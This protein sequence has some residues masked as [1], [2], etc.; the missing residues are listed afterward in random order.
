[1][2]YQY[3][4]EIVE[5]EPL[6]WFGVP[7]SQTAAFCKKHGIEAD[8]VKSKFIFKTDFF[9]YHL[10]DG[11]RICTRHDGSKFVCQEKIFKEHWR[12]VK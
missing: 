12:K 11:D 1:M 7:M 8:L 9:T 4:E 3:K 10:K 2:R 6:E 5:A